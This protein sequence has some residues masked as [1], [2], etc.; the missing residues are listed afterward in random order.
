VFVTCFVHDYVQ[1]LLMFSLDVFVL[2]LIT[3]FVSDSIQAFF[4]I[5]CVC[6]CVCVCVA[7][8]VS[9]VFV[10]SFICID[11]LMIFLIFW[12]VVALMQNVCN[13]FSMFFIQTLLVVVF[14]AVEL[15]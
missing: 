11:T 15:L 3:C 4:T 12:C 13:M 9:K 8:S 2:L 6:V 1:A 5:V 14:L 7:P 10:A